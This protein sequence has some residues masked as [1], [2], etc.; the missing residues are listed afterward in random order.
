MSKKIANTLLSLATI[1]ALGGGLLSY[2]YYYKTINESESGSLTVEPDSATTSTGSDTDKWRIT[3]AKGTSPFNLTLTSGVLYGSVDDATYTGKGVASFDIDDFLVSSGAVS[4]DYSGGQTAN[5]NDDGYLSASDWTNFNNKQDTLSFND[6]DFTV[7]LNSISIDYANGQTASSILK[8]F[9]SSTDWSTFNSKQG[10]LTFGDLTVAS[11]KIALVGTGTNA[12]IGAGLSLD[13]NEANII[14]NN[15]AGLATGDPHTQYLLLAGRTGGQTYYGGTEVGDSIT[16][17]GTSNANKTGSTVNMQTGGGLVVIGSSTSLAQLAMN[18]ELKLNNVSANNSLRSKMFSGAIKFDSSVTGSRIYY[19]LNQSTIESD[20]T[21]SSQIKVPSSNPSATIGIGGFSSSNSS[22]DV[23]NAFQMYITSNG[24]LAIT[25]TGTANTDTRTA[26]ISDFVTNYGGKIVSV[27]AV[28]NTTTPS[29]TIYIDG[30]SQ[31]YTESTS[32][33]APTWA[34]S[35]T[36]TYTIIGA[37][38]ST[39]IY[40]DYIYG[41]TAYNKGLTSAETI[42]LQE[43]GVASSDQWGR[44]IIGYNPPVLNGGFETTGTGGF[45]DWAEAVVGASTINVETVDVHSGSRAARLDIDAS[46]NQARVYQKVT[47]IGK[48]YRLSFWAK[49]NDDTGNSSMKVY[50]STTPAYLTQDL[51]TVWTKYSVDFT[52]NNEYISFARS[53]AASK[54]IYLDDVQLEEIGA[55]LDADLQNANPSIT[56]AVADRSSNNLAGIAT[57]TGLAQVNTS[58]NNHLSLTSAEITESASTGD[59]LVDATGWTST[60]WTGDYNTGFTHTTGN[61]NALSRTMSSTGTN[62]Y[63]VSFTVDVAV[64][65][66]DLYVTLG[67]SSPYDMYNGAAAGSTYTA[68]IKSVSNGDLVF[69][70]VS[71]FNGTITNISVKQITGNYTPTLVMND[72]TSTAGL[73]IRSNSSELKNVFIGVNSGQYNTTGYENASIG[74]RSLSSNTTGYWNSALGYL[75]LDNNT[76]GSRN[77][78]IGYNSL[79]LN[80]SG[81][82][83]IGVGTFTLPVNTTGNKNIAM[84]AD[85]LFE[86]TTGSNNIGIGYSALSDNVDGNYNTALGDNALTRVVSGTN[87]I[88]LGYYA[89]NYETGSNSLYIDALSRGSLADGKAKSLIYGIFDADPANQKLTFNANVGVGLLSPTASLNIRAGTATASTAP[90]KFTSGTLLTTEEAGAVEFLTDTLYYT[91]TNGVAGSTKRQA[92]PGVTNGT[93]APTSTPVRVG[94]IY[95]DTTNKK[96]YMSVGTSSS[97]DWVILN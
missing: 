79:R 23:G 74:Y 38:D 58:N 69:T 82:R 94:D 14:H 55:T 6:N 76:V 27:T 25:L 17:Q 4:I 56:T 50:G 87:N 39:K 33:T 88:G 64:G 95:S 16:I 40:N 63:Q 83:N 30:L 11:N 91:A 28:R 9:L 77:I 73:E 26:T 68:G 78:A 3:S 84:G 54:S 20:F 53:L 86:N 70:P 67:N 72:S 32:G 61:T 62:M 59:E 34:G 15:L 36:S 89:G 41:F 35:V 21:L 80:I 75:A 57:S 10:A 48:Q 52:A 22:L 81:Q 66:G 90:L 31:T 47:T 29:M 12:L 18:G 85:A 71:G 7:A 60:G 45:A 46:N 24:E 51:T 5:K 93:A 43:V 13:I 49:I 1:I 44:I 92:I 42:S 97:A 65:S 19:T 37:F 2:V 96:I 8:G